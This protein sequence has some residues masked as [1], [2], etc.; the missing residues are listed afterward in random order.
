MAGHL[1]HLQRLFEGRKI[2][3]AV[4]HGTP[5]K[6]YQHDG[7]VGHTISGTLIP[8]ESIAN[9]IDAT[10]LPVF[11]FHALEFFSEEEKQANFDKMTTQA[12]ASAQA[13]LVHLERFA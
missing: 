5:V 13:L 11:S 9:Y 1:V 12:Q 6:D 4:S 8:F 3:L 2:G 10:F 7:K